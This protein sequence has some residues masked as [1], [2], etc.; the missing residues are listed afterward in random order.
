ML[1]SYLFSLIHRYLGA[2]YLVTIVPTSVHSNF[3]HSPSGSIR[4]P[5]FSTTAFVLALFPL[6]LVRLQF[7]GVSYPRPPPF[8]PASYCCLS[9]ALATV[10]YTR[11]TLY[12]YSFY[13][14]VVVPYHRYTVLSYCSTTTWGLLPTS[15]SFLA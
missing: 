2:S 11:A 8:I 7:L 10:E 4:L 3:S 1:F 9:S 14:C 6:S 13:R 5:P 12:S 15:H